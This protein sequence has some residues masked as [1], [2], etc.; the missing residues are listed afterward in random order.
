[1]TAIEELLQL[2][3]I[4]QSDNRIFQNAL[5]LDFKDYEDAVQHECAAA[6]KLD[7]IVTR[8]I[9][10]YRNAALEVYSPGDFLKILSND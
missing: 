9:K 3:E 6:E 5:S 7:A 4:A 10:D 2:V 8:N 1:M